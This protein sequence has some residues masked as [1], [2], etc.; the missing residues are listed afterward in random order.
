MNFSHEE[1]HPPVP[2]GLFSQGD[3]NTAQGKDAIVV[4]GGPGNQARPGIPM[5]AGLVLCALGG[6]SA[7]LVSPIA[8]LLVGFGALAAGAGRSRRL[9]AAIIAGTLVLSGMGGAFFGA[10]SVPDALVAA[11]VGLASAL[12]VE[13]GRM[14]PGAACL[15]ALAA[16]A[17]HIGIAE[18]Y[19]LAW[20][21]TLA[22]SLAGLVSEN[23]QLFE[24]A[25][26][27]PGTLAVVQRVVGIIWPAVFSTLAALELLCACAGAALAAGRLRDRVAEVPDFGLFDLPLWVVAIFVAAVVGLAV[28]FTQPSLAT[29]ALLMV[30]GNAL[31]T[32]RYALAAQGIAVLVWHLRSRKTPTFAFVLAVAFA[33]YL[34]AQF[35]VMSF[36]GLL[37]IWANLRRLPRGAQESSQDGA[38]Q[39]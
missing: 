24:A 7:G 16:A 30:A 29:D 8:C 28:W 25:G 2:E 33:A 20:Q 34:E 6:L 37:D 4:Y 27:D 18:A 15:V 39:D 14:T 1:G 22:D 31:L 3:K 17:A 35:I 12:L 11:L 13:K 32:V 19:A 5:A 21:T 36:V 26:V 23:T 10:E 38:K 9:R